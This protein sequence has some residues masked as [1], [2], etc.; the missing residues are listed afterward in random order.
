MQTVQKLPTP[1][2][3][4]KRLNCDESETKQESAAAARD[5][6]RECRTATEPVAAD[7]VAFPHGVSAG[8]K[9][10]SGESDILREGSFARVVLAAL[11]RSDK[12]YDRVLLQ[13]FFEGGLVFAAGS[14]EEVSAIAFGPRC[15]H[16]GV[17]LLELRLGVGWRRAGNVRLF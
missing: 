4:Q 7:R 5:E 14:G 3:K 9:A 11:G 2:S 1:K 16:E 12:F 8:T 15:G 10:E 13:I 6:A 17:D